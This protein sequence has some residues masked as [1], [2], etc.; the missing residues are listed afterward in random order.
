MSAD[1]ILPIS[2]VKICIQAS[3]KIRS[4]SFYS[5]IKFLMSVT[6]GWLASR[7]PA[8]HFVIGFVLFACPLTKEYFIRTTCLRTYNSLGS[9]GP[10]FI[11]LI[12]IEIN[13]RSLWRADPRPSANIHAHRRFSTCTHDINYSKNAFEMLTQ[14][15]R[16]FRGMD[17]YFF[18]I[19]WN[20]FCVT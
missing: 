20:E 19:I 5:I 17:R 10:L 6:L 2:M 16:N 3:P 15:V 7:I 4:V 9:R 14:Y 8:E 1:G 11:F 12:K 18:F 13:S